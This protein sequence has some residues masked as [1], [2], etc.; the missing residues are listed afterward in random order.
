MKSDTLFFHLKNDYSGSTRVLATIIEEEYSNVIVPVITDG[1]NGA[2]FLS[3]MSNVKVVSY[4]MLKFRNRPIP[5]LTAFIWRLHSLLLSLLYGWRYDKFYINTI[6]PYYAALVG[7]LYKKKI[8]YHVHEYFS[9]STIPY[10][11]MNYF[12]YN[13]HSYHIYVSK[14]LK[15]QYHE[16][17]NNWEIKYNKLSKSFIKDVHIRP[18]DERNRKSIIMLC[19]LTTAKGVDTFVKLA[20]SLSEY[21]FCLVL[22]ANTKEITDFFNYELP[23]NL[24]LFPSQNDIHRFLYNSDLLLNLS[25]PHLWVETFGMTI[26]EAMSY[27][28]PSIAPNVGGPLELVENGYNGFCVDVT[29]ISLVIDKIRYIL[30]E[31]NYHRMCENTFKRYRT[32]FS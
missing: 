7:M 17:A 29:N 5:F 11:I 28:I 6:T 1:N 26:L 18:I 24:T 15:S 16:K 21:N 13:S 10:K 22:N 8:I 32:F 14:Y 25:K 3:N 12:F 9:Y 27:G 31:N 30:N 4:K 20:L 2:G 19:S 23:K